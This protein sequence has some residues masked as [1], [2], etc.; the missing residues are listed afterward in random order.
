MDALCAVQVVDGGYF[1]PSPNVDSL[2]ILLERHPS[3]ITEIDAELPGVVLKEI[4]S[5]LACCTQLVSLT[6]AYSHDPAV[7]LGLSQLHTL[8]GVNLGA[9]SA[10]AIAAALPKL[11]TLTAFGCEGP[12]QTACFFTDLLPRLRIFHYDGSWPDAQE[13]PPASFV[14]PLPLL[15]E[16]VWELTCESESFTPREFLGA[17]PKVLHAPYALIS[18]CWL[19]EVD[20]APGFLARVCDLRITT[21]S[22]VDPLDP[23]DVA[24]VLRAAP[25]LKKLFT[26][27]CVRGAASWLAPTAPTHPAFEGLVHP[28]LREFGIVCADGARA[29]TT[30]PDA[31]WVVHLRRRHFPRLRKLVVGDDVSFITP[32]DNS[33]T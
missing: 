6:S 31:E 5:A 27:H 30:S 24:H 10:A 18:Q 22:D 9:V 12:S 8:R 2:A 15:E 19:G 11:R 13:Q 1:S 32:P 7:W 4:S 17:Q 26:S 25:Q 29:E 23:T 14:A 28:R 3:T 21:L 20:G 16:L 33:S